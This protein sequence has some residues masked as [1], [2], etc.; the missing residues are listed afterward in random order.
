MAT[1]ADHIALA[2]KNHAVLVHLLEDVEKF[3][4]WVAVTAFY[5]AL[6]IV[7]AVFVHKH[8]RS[9][10][11]HPERL[12]ALKRRGYEEEHKHFR[13]LWA[14]SSVARYLHDAGS[15]RSYCSFTD[16]MAPDRVRKFVQKRLGGVECNAVRHLS[17]EGRDALERF[18]W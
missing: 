4:E 2:N 14:A 7:E 10:H 13:V 3:P 18:A 5:K 6:Q 16:Y 1:E 11:G 15:G 8:G 12:N 9:C 17:D